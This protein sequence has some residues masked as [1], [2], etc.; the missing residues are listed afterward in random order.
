MQ[1]AGGSP[2]AGCGFCGGGPLL[3]ALR[4]R[5]VHPVAGQQGEDEVRRLG[6]EICLA[7]DLAD[8]SYL[9]KLL[10]IDACRTHCNG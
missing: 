10:V 6:A 4:G 5:V 1:Q 9:T 2:G 3:A 7:F 8:L